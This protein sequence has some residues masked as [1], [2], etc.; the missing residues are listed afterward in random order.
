MYNSG[1]TYFP[2][3]AY[4]YTENRSKMGMSFCVIDVMQIVIIIIII[5]IG[6]ILLQSARKRDAHL[7]FNLS[8]AFTTI[9]YCKKNFDKE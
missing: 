6:V 9:Y 1:N 4:E 5:I 2:G 3:S 8:T 7:A